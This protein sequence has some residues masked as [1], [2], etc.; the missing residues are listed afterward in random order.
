MAELLRK[1]IRDSGMS[2]GELHR[3]TG[4]KQPTISTFLNGAGISLST[5]QVLA[6]YFGLVL[7]KKPTRK[8][9]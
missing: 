2:A 3:Q 4:V 1:T 7:S 9:K 5:A 6:D 8:K